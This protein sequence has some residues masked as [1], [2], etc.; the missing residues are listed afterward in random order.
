MAARGEAHALHEPLRTL[1]NVGE[2]F[3]RSP[4]CVFVAERPQRGATQILLDR[5][6][7]KD[8]GDLKAARQAAPI[9]LERGKPGDR[10][11]VQAHLARARPDAA[12]REVEERRFAGAVR[13]DDRV[14]FALIN[15]ER[16][17]PDDLH[18][19]EIL[20]KI[21]ERKRRVHPSPRKC[22]PALTAP[23]ASPTLGQ[24]LKTRTVPAANS[25]TATIHGGGVEA[26]T[27]KPKRRIADPSLRASASC[28]LASSMIM[29]AP[30]PLATN[31]GPTAA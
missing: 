21:E 12:A 23:H 20:A 22:S 11:A 6:L 7:G 31:A 25:A 18:R 17:A 27:S 9:D 5:H 1:A 2:P 15:V 29:I 4:E 13:P 24:S 26:S 14:P 30:A 28:R 19:A 3:D 10:L 8:I 16:D